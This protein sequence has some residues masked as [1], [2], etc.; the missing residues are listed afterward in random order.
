MLEA[1]VVV[2]SCLTLSLFR[3]WATPRGLAVTENNH[4][5]DEASHRDQRILIMQCVDFQETGIIQS[6]DRLKFLNKFYFK[7][8]ASV[9]LPVN[10]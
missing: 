1:P 8:L 2:F 5:N 3:L 4:A 10:H 7:V 9:S 6:A